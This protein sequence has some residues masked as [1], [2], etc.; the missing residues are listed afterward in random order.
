M[1]MHVEIAQAIAVVAHG[2]RWL[3]GDRAHPLELEQRNSAFWQVTR[4]EF[5]LDT[6]SASPVVAASVGEWLRWVADR[7]AERLWLF[8]EPPDRHPWGILAALG[9]SQVLWSR[10]DGGPIEH[11]PD[12]ELRGIRYADVQTT[13]HEIETPSLDVACDGLR[14]AV[15]DA[16]EFASEHQLDNWWPQRFAEALALASSTDPSQP[17]YPD[18]MPAR[19]YTREARALLATAAHAWV[20]GGMASWNDLPDDAAD[21]PRYEPLSDRLYAR[22]WD[23]FLASV[24][25][26]I[27]ESFTPRS[28]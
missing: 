20:F 4:V 10:T 12:S 25:S 18:M 19:G 3:A 7:G 21:D 17:D 28:D 27:L 1:P 2:S 9:G 8:A 11:D 16:R 5:V 26:P 13:G 23:A 15:E 14:E 24:N 22:I 6:P